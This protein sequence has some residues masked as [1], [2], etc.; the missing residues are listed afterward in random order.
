MNMMLTSSQSITIDVGSTVTDT[1]GV[2]IRGSL[3]VAVAFRDFR[4]PALVDL[5]WPIAYATCIKHLRS[6][7]CRRRCRLNLHL[8]YNHL[9]KPASIY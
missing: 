8:L 6:R 3:T 4:T 9:H 2:G 7:R 1:I 5:A